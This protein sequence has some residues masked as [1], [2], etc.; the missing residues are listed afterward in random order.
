[1]AGHKDDGK[2]GLYVSEKNMARGDHLGDAG[3]AGREILKCV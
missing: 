1:L 3:M 2:W